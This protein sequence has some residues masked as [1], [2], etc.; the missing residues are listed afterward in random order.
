ML[1]GRYKKLHGKFSNFKLGK[2]L[3]IEKPKDS[4]IVCKR[5]VKNESLLPFKIRRI[6]K[7]NNSSEIKQSKLA[8]RK[9]M[10]NNRVK[11]R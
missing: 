1:S 7:N 3:C 4:S 8:I 6:E 5:E 10:I 2:T 9:Y 11:E